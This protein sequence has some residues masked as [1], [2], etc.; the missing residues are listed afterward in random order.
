MMKT[1]ALS[2]I[3][4]RGGPNRRGSPIATVGSSGR[5]AR[6]SR[7]FLRSLRERPGLMCYATALAANIEMGA[8]LFV[9]VAAQVGQLAEGRFHE[10]N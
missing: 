2:A 1:R 5:A 10:A 8:A 3:P 6:C 9:G 7:Q 4:A